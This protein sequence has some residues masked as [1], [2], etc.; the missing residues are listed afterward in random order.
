MTKPLILMTDPRWFDV[1]YQINPWMRPGVWRA[2][3][4]AH[5]R[6]ARSAFDALVAA[7]KHAGATVEIIDGARGLP[8]M[9][10]A[11][12][13][14]VVLDGRV[15]VGRFRPTERQGEEA[16]YLAAFRALQARGLVDEVAQ[17]SAGVFQ[18]GAGDAI[19]DAHRGQFWTGFGQRSD[20]A[21]SD[22]IAAHFGRDVVPLEL[23]SPRFYHLDTC[24]CPLSGGEVLY[25]PPAFT[26]AALAEIHARV[27]ADQRIVADDAAAAGLCVNAVSIGDTVVMAKAPASLRRA[28]ERCGYRV[29]V[30]DLAPFCLSGGAAFCLTLRLD[31]LALAAAPAL[32][33]TAA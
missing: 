17:I 11:A 31:Q 32:A 21:A 2:D 23:A 24:F 20:R 3:A 15:L 19:W 33:T 25:Y 16:R 14:A 12:N 7:L 4:A 8:D 27:P 30:V 1:S 6:A 18:E 5:Q 10:F 13:A 28:L 9:V 29:V 22:A 26:A